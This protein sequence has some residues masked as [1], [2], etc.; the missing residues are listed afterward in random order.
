[1]EMTEKE[2]VDSYNR[3]VAGPATQI[4]V[5]AELNDTTYTEIEKILVNAGEEVPK[6]K[7]R[8]PK[9]AKAEQQKV[10]DVL[11][12]IAYEKLDSL[13]EE[14]QFHKRKMEEAAATYKEIT[15]FI[16]I[17]PERKDA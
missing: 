2:I 10:P 8:K 11:L 14:I 7:G 17:R 1:M 13:E 6:K 4:Q 3:R 16:G 9:T 12:Q 5:L 15:D